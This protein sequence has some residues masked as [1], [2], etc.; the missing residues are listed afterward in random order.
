VDAESLKQ[1]ALARPI[2]NWR[3]GVRS[4]VDQSF[5]TSSDQN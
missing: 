5:R 3:G 4:S 1:Q 2:V